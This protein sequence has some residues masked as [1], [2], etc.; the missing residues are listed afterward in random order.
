[1]AYKLQH[2]CCCYPEYLR[3]YHARNHATGPVPY[4]EGLRRLMDDQFAWADFFEKN[5][6][7]L[8][9]D[10]GLLLANEDSLQVQWCKEKTH[11][12]LIAAYLEAFASGSSQKIESVRRETA[13]AQIRDF[14]PD[15]LFVDEPFS[16]GG[17]WLKDVVQSVPSIRL[18]LGFVGCDYTPDMV[19]LLAPFHRIGCCTPWLE[20]K[21]RRDGLR[22]FLLNHAFEATVLHNTPDPGESFHG[23]VFGGSL[24]PGVHG[25]RRML[26]EVMAR[27]G[28]PLR[29]HTS[30]LRKLDTLDCWGRKIRQAIRPKPAAVLERKNFSLPLNHAVRAPIFG[31]AMYA[32]FRNAAIVFNSH[33]GAINRH[34]GNMRLFEA[35]GAGACL[36]T[37]WKEN[38]AGLYEPDVEVAAYRS[39]AECAEKARW[40]M[41]HPTERAAMAQRGQ[42][43][44]LK[45]H[46]FAHRAAQLDNLIRKTL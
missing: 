37:D 20:E 13:A 26:L 40:L 39:P 11:S 23:V 36:L 22:P 44:T 31:R 7:K 19:S 10:A 3:D 5:L 35:T 41:D 29:V 46:T 28:L 32:L 8:G 17:A 9:V 42:A 6:L 25:E 24:Y 1:M 30:S 4:Q 45:E 43:R 33:G 16:F 34:A 27:A 2:L 12:N 38:L 14:R 21:L 15:V 18:V